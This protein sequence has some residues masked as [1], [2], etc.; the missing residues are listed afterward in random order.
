M[1]K[2]LDDSSAIL[3]LEAAERL[4]LKSNE[5]IQSSNESLLAEVDSLISNLAKHCETQIHELK[6]PTV[7]EI[8]RKR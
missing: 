4:R 8:S 7:A 1:T 5:N 3:S 2:S 6:S